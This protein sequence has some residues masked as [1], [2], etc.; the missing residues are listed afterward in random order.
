MSFS[1]KTAVVTGG[2]KGIGG[3]CS[4]IFY[5]ENANVVILDTDPQGQWLAAELGA[6][7]LFLQCDVSKEAQVKAAM[8]KA[9]ETF[10]GIDILINNAGIQRYSTVTETS[11][12]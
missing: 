11:E 8:E 6:R 12:E 9:V 4:R 1:N 5:R 3:A 10:G 2:A 7:A